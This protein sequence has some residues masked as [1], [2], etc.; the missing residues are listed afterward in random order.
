[1]SKDIKENEEEIEEER[2]DENSNKCCCCYS[3]C[4]LNEYSYEQNSTYFCYVYKRKG[5]CYWFNNYISNSIQKQICQLIIQYFTLMN[6]TIAFDKVLN[7]SNDN[8]YNFQFNFQELI[9]IL[10]ILLPSWIIFIYF[11][12]SF[13]K[14][15]RALHIY[16]FKNEGKNKLSIASN[17]I[18]VG[19]RGIVFFNA[20]YSLVFSS[21]YLAGNIS[22]EKNNIYLIYIPILIHK[23]YYFTLN[24]YCISYSKSVKILN[25]FLAQN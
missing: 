5:I 25:C 6:L 20:I 24:Y 12:I 18:L 21:F 14:L 11:S 13:S 3:F 7:S 2:K 4:D 19:M 22:I 15:M 8:N 16:G 1:M 10:K 23:L 17:Y 9:Y